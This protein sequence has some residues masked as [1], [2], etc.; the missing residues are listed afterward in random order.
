MSIE[1]RVVSPDEC[2]KVH[3]LL[4]S[5]FYCISEP[6]PDF[7]L[8]GDIN[9]GGFDGD[10]LVGFV[11]LGYLDLNL[12]SRYFGEP[13]MKT[14]AWFSAVV[15]KDYRGEGLQRRMYEYAE[16]FLPADVRYVDT[17][18]HYSNLPS[19]SNIMKA[20]FRHAGRY[21]KICDRCGIVLDHRH[22]AFNFEYFV[23]KLR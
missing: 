21:C 17:T 13:S 12:A 10:R 14:M 18:A 7:H 19:I 6:I 20:G 16:S 11:D 3:D 4:L 15:D 5:E 8:S 1:I 23:K 2:L 22:P 9:V